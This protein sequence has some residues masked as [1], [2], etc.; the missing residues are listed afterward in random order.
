MFWRTLQQKEIDIIEESDG[1]LTAIEVKWN[2]VKKN[3]TN[4]KQF[5]EVY[6]DA[7]FKVITPANVDEYLLDDL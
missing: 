6:P 4:H 2:P 7:E 1:R 5:A 3:V